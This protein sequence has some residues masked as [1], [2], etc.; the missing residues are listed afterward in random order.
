MPRGAGR[1]AGWWQ[2]WGCDEGVLVSLD[3]VVQ[4]CGFVE[5]EGDVGVGHEVI[6]NMVAG[7]LSTVA[8]RMRDDH[9]AYA[10]NGG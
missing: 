7:W 10:N 5:G 9:H 1:V 8:L 2:W 6:V 3:A 4:L